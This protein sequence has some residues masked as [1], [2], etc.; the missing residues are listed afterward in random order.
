MWN[1]RPSPADSSVRVSSTDSGLP[2]I[3]RREPGKD[4][5]QLGMGESMPILQ[6]AN[7]LA[8]RLS[9]DSPFS[10]LDAIPVYVPSLSILE[11]L[12]IYD[13]RCLSSRSRMVATSQSTPT[14]KASFC[15][16]VY[17]MIYTKSIVPLLGYPLSRADHF[18]SD[19]RVPPGIDQSF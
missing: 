12:D 4:M 8:D 13:D 1:R 18:N 19:G 6:T 2:K 7:R 17:A 11:V 14:H 15:I 10:R 5:T 16:S 3:H 9:G